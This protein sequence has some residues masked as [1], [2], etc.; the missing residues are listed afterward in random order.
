MPSTSIALISMPWSLLNRPS[1]QLGGLKAYLEERNCCRVDCHH[2]YLGAARALGTEA[3]TTL[4]ANSWAGEALYAGLLFPERREQAQHV[5][6]KSCRDTK[7]LVHGFCDFQ[8]ALDEH[9]NTWIDGLELSRYRLIGF[10]VCFSQLFSSLLAAKK[11]KRIAP[12][13]PI[14][15][16]GSSCCGPMAASLKK[17]FNQVD[18]VIDGEG[19][20]QLYNLVSHLAGQ[21][22]EQ[23]N[24]CLKLDSLPVPDYRPYF[25]ELA[26]LFPGM[27]FQPRLPVEFS[28]GCWWNRCTFCNLNVQWHGYRRKSAEKMIETVD[29]LLA[30]HRSLDFSFCDNALPPGET[31]AF[32][33]HTAGLGID[34]R[35]F[36][37]IRS[38]SD[39]EKLSRYRRGGLDSVQVGIESLSRSLL[40]KMDKGATVIENLAIM[41]YCA[42]NGITLDG[43][44]I[45][46]FPGSTEEEVEET[47]KNLEYCLP[48]HPLSAASFFL[49]AGSPI[50][51]KPKEY[52]I[53]AI[54]AHSY[55]NK[56]L[57]EDIA[58]RLPLPVRDYRGD[59]TRQRKRWRPVV[60]MIR[61]WQD[62]H[63]RRKDSSIP[64]LSY[65]DGG[66]F[67]I[68]RQE[69]SQAPPL[70]H[71]LQGTSRQLYLFCATIRSLTEIS[72]HFPGVQEK[73]ILQFFRDLSKKRL[74]FREKDTVLSLAIHRA[75]EKR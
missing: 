25:S 52:G 35:F 36:A 22:V 7:E 44:L 65:R 23:E 75:Q 11:I 59:K 38:I 31:D 42:E 3:Y 46:E 19:E 1:I 71:R 58:A 37:E 74:L 29:T 28:R 47:L 49:G 63:R 6:E 16:G 69:R 67:L 54:T 21:V 9:L 15:F 68:I 60:K 40:K 4:S 66:S 61:S 24:G 50:A 51:A 41:K 53:R 43:N 27:P 39:P 56:L 73:S 13:I 33:A 72:E 30:R 8:E 57:P 45:I 20:Q 14:V 10:S 34:L 18:H 2:P 12:A 32:F 17:I 62:F 26:T 5:F 64:A 48:Y 55:S 70:L